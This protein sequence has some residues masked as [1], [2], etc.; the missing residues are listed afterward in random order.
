[1]TDAIIPRTDFLGMDEGEGH[2]FSFFPKPIQT[3][4]PTRCVSI[5]EVYHYIVDPQYAKQQTD[6]LRSMTDKDAAKKYKAENFDFC[7]FS[8]IFQRRCKDGLVQ[9]S[10]LLCLDFDHVADLPGLR[11]RLLHDEYFATELL[12]RSP[13]GDGH[14]H[15]Y[16]RY[17]C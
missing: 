15:R 7:T 4:E 14:R 17:Y 2:S 3:K 12:F 16:C 8:G 13:S 1:M 5:P 9:H 10:G 11:E 6:M